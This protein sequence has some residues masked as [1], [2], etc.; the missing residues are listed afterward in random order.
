MVGLI[1]PNYALALNEAEVQEAFEVPLAF[2]MDPANHQRQSRVREGIRRYFFAMP[3]GER[4]IWGV[5][6]GLIR[7]LYEKLYA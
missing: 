6:A 1:P 7:N 3:Y 2:L 4:F 5:T